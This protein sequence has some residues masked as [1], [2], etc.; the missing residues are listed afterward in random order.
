M[1]NSIYFTPIPVKK[2]PTVCKKRL[3]KGK[4]GLRCERQIR[5]H[6]RGENGVNQCKN[7]GK[8]AFFNG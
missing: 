4:Y 8:T 3:K 2:Q 5:G 7:R 6:H 1:L